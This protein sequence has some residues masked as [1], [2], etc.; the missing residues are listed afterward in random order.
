MTKIKFISQSPKKDVKENIQDPQFKNVN[1]RPLQTEP[2]QT[3]PGQKSSKEIEEHTLD[4]RSAPK[5]KIKPPKLPPNYLTKNKIEPPKNKPNDMPINKIEPPTLEPY[6]TPKNKIRSPKL[7]PNYLTKNKIEQPTLEPHYTTKN[8]ITPPKLQPSNSTKNQTQQHNM[9]PHLSPKNKI[10]P[11]KSIVKNEPIRSN[12]NIGKY[13]TDNFIKD[14]LKAAMR[15]NPEFNSLSITKLRE[16]ISTEY[17]GRGKEFLKHI[18]G[19]IQN[20]NDPGYNPDYKFSKQQIKILRENLIEPNKKKDSEITKI[21][22]KYQKCNPKLKDYSRQ[23]W[24]IS[25]P[26]LKYNYFKKIDTKEKAYWLGFLG[27][28][29]SITGGQDSTRK[30]YQI[31]VEL[32][33]KDKEH[34]QN[35]CKAL[36]LNPENKL[37]DRDKLIDYNGEQ[38]NFKLANVQFTCK[39]MFKD[40][41][42]IRFKKIPQFVSNLNDSNR[43]L[44]L[45]WLLGVYDADGI[46]GTTKICSSEKWFLKKIKDVFN[47]K[48]DIYIKNRPSKDEIIK[49]KKFVWEFSLGAVLFNEM[50]HRSE[51][52]INSLKRKRK[53]FDP[54]REVYD[55]LISNIGNKDNLQILVDRFTVRDVADCLGVNIKTLRKLMTQYKISAPRKKIDYNGDI[56]DLIKLNHDKK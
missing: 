20:P 35:F 53:Y 26:T 24:Q 33:I 39:P 25:E 49:S 2:S 4:P 45:A 23:Q 14:F 27:R 34:L 8:K 42:E 38:K 30:R 3:K 41:Q 46:E 48:Y 17:F 1:L 16:K 18:L 51:N 22:E 32:G 29:G 28:D 15:I 50:M 13:S 54:Y 19:R 56:S 43:E 10:T 36:G 5:N 11:F 47:I 21:I 12:T 40:L 9:L 55:L 44:A 52:C 37:N 6:Y 7:P 31:A